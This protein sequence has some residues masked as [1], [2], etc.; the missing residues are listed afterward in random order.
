MASKSRSGDRNSVHLDAAVTSCRI[1]RPE[2]GAPEAEVFV[3]T[4]HPRLPAPEVDGERND[5]YMLHYVRVPVTGA[6]G[7]FVASLAR[8]TE[9][10]GI[11]SMIPCSVDGSLVSEEDSVYIRCADG[12]FAPADSLKTSGNN[13]VDIEGEVV[14]VSST[15]ESATLTVDSGGMRLTSHIARSVCPEA[16]AMVG[17]GKL[18][19][20]SRI[21]LKGQLQSR[22]YIAGGRAARMAV[23]LPVTVNALKRAVTRD[24]RPSGPDL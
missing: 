9:N 16:F 24:V 2:G 22:I 20:G 11:R 10:G 5:S 8:E 12:G 19:K 6:A 1:I 7:E 23:I 4:V 17:S 13:R 18:V 21:A 15:R 14:S 3:V